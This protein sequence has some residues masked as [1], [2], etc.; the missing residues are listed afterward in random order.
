MPAVHLG[1]EKGSSTRAV[2]PHSIGPIGLEEKKERAESKNNASAAFGEGKRKLAERER[3]NHLTV[4][5]WVVLA[6]CV[7][8]NEK[9]MS[10]P[11]M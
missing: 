2:R 5:S 11:G 1:W 3:R 8:S 6:Q 4:A 9:V 7:R 10:P